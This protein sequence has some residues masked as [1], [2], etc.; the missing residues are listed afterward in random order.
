MMAAWSMCQVRFGS[1]KGSEAERVIGHRS[2]ETSIARA[3]IALAAAASVAGVVWRMKGVASFAL[4]IA[5]STLALRQLMTAPR[6][7]AQ[8]W[9]RFL[10]IFHHMLIRF[11]RVPELAQLVASARLRPAL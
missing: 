8:P 11:I 7:E 6:P 9:R 1:W 2:S 4:A 5:V 10:M 3:M